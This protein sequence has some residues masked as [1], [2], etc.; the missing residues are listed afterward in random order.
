MTWAFFYI[1]VGL[2]GYILCRG[3]DPNTCP[4]NNVYPAPGYAPSCKYECKN[5]QTYETPNYQEGTFCF[6]YHGDLTMTLHH[7]GACKDGECVPENRAANGSLPYQWAGIYHQCEDLESFQNPIVN[8]TYICSRQEANYKHREY[9][10]GIYKDG[11]KCWMG[12]GTDFGVCRSGICHNEK[13]ISSIDN[14]AP[15]SPK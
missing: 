10:Y 3:H 7:L 14:V 8:C 5:G 11:S 6:V 9:Y 2:F 13:V 15:Q 4:S 1:I 12:T